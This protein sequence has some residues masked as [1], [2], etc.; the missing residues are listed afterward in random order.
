MNETAA[1]ACGLF[2]GYLLGAIPA[3]FLIAKWGF[4][5]DLRPFG[6]GNVGATNALRALGP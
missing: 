6:S 3:S 5:L 1:I 4:G 2:V